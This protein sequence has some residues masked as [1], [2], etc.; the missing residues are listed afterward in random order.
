M[1]AIFHNPIQALVSRFFTH[2][3]ANHVF[4]DYHIKAGK[5]GMK[6]VKDKVI[7]DE[8]PWPAIQIIVAYK[9]DLITTDLICFDMVLDDGSLI[10][11]NEEM[12]GFDHLLTALERQFPLFDR[13]WPDKVVHPPFA[14]NRTIVYTGIGVD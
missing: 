13:T 11:I 10:E 6:L 12:D 2:R 9:R 5:A 3:K 7:V 1:G 4:A 14:P 8:I